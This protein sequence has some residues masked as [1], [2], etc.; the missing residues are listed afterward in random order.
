MC[1]SIIKFSGFP[2]LVRRT[3]AAAVFVALAMTSMRAVYA[4]Q[5]EVVL[6]LP[7]PTA[8]PNSL[9][10][11]R[12]SSQYDN[13]ACNM[14]F[15][16]LLEYEY[17]ERP[18]KLKPC[19]LAEMPIVTDGGK[20]FRFRLK[21]GVRFHDDPCFPDGKGREMVADD[22]F[23]S[24][25]RMAD[26][27]NSPKAWWLLQDTIVGFDQWRTD[28]NAADEKRQAFI[29]EKKEAGEE[30]SESAAPIGFDYDAPVEGMK[31]INDYEFEIL[32][33][34][35]FFRFTYTLAMFQTSVVAR[36]AAEHYGNCLLYTSPSPRDRG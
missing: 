18:Y 8:G 5:P 3:V 21:K 36:E 35:P 23:Y 28:Q 30:D 10:P 19:L 11:V 31:K 25:K 32:L 26:K 17:L 16:T 34:Q 22:V 4:V 27:R 7:M 20:R 2:P 24:F 12:G 13:R 15:E 9:D 6:H 33:K 29:E 1:P 14:V